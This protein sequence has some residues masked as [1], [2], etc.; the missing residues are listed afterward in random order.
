MLHTNSFLIISV[1]SYLLLNLLR[2]NDVYLLMLRN[3]GLDVSDRN[4]ENEP[5]G[6]QLSSFKTLYSRGSATRLL[7]Q[8]PKS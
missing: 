4:L 3:C 5:F 7:F 2:I 8:C 1:L 6:H